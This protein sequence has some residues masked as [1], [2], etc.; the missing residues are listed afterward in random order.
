MRTPTDGTPRRNKHSLGN[1]MQILERTA[2][3]S[4]QLASFPMVIAPGIDAINVSTN[5]IPK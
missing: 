5:K 4:N 3:A 2:A 1:R